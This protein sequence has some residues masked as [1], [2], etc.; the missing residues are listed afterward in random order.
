MLWERIVPCATFDDDENVVCNERM[1]VCAPRGGYLLQRQQ[2][3]VVC[4]A[5]VCIKNEYNTQK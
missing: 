3:M 2:T 1:C 5:V 4:M